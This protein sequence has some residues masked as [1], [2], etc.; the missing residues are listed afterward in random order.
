MKDVQNQ[1]SDIKIKLNLVGVKDVIYPISLVD[2]SNNIQNTVASIAMYVNLPKSKKG[3][4][5]SRFLEVL[6]QNKN[7]HLNS[8]RWFPMLK[9]LKKTFKCSR[10]EINVKTPYFIKKEAPVSKKQ[11]LLKIDC[12][13]KCILNGKKQEIMS[14]KVPVTSLCPCSKEISKYGAHNQRSFVKVELITKR[15]IW[16]E[17]LVKIIE[18]CASCA[19]YPLLKRSDEKYVTEKAYENPVF[20]EDLVRDVALKMKKDKRVT[21]FRVTVE[22]QESIHDH[23]VFA[24]YEEGVK[25]EI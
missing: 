23:N 18:D 13:F 3:T 12:R 21:W 15:F 9:N 1:K 11:S 24:V 16:I 10:T 8:S 20:V 19:I 7:I 6:N 4:H 22:N 5:M 25:K 14:I 2:K 17:D